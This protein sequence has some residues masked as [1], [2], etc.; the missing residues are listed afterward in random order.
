MKKEVL[1]QEITDKKSE[2]SKKLE[3]LGLTHPHCIDLNTEINQLVIQH[4]K[5]DLEEE[6]EDLLKEIN[7]EK[8]KLKT[9]A[10]IH[11][12]ASNVVV[13]VSEKLDELIL[14]YQKLMLIL[15]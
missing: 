11:S 15:K 10:T 14:R 3:E 5:S 4:Q 1:L 9:V 8:S 13:E 7:T 6:A 12:C 2:L